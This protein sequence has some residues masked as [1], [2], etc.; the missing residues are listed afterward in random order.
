MKFRSLAL[1][2]ALAFGLSVSAED[3][4][5]Y[6]YCHM[7]GNSETT[8]Y[9]LGSKADR[10]EKYHA[11][12]GNQPVFDAEKVARIEGG[13]RDAFIMRGKNNDYLMCVT[14]MCNRK[15]RCWNNYGIDLLHSNDLVHWTSVTFDFR[16]G[17]GIFSDP[18]SPDVIDY[19]KVNRVWAP[20][21]IWDK[22]YKNGKG[23]WLVYYSILTD[24]PGEYDKIYYSYAN[25]DF[26]TLTKPQLF[27]DKGI[28]VIDCHIDWNEHD[29][30]Y[31]VFYKKE[32]AAGYDRGIWAATFEKLPVSEWTDR[33]HITNEGKEQVEGV[34]AFRLIGED[35]WKVAYIR[36]SG[37]K[38]YKIC[39]A[40][41]NLTNVDKGI[42]LPES[43]LP[44]H[45]SFMTVTKDEYDML[46]AW[47]KL[48]VKRSQP[49]ADK[50]KIDAILAKTYK[51]GAVKKL[52]KLYS[53]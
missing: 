26:T 15:S 37:G 40:D 31:H 1:C 12:A 16:Q 21:V 13:T 46:E 25:D 48:M 3:Y 52:L 9:A 24:K 17:P 33:F 51:K 36:Y 47:S 5:G 10:G 4:Y 41:A 11:L 34:S 29:G 43:L 50:A 53:K 30:L 44:Q 39:N 7:S 22:D 23:G 35:A 14:D 38:A 18:E 49:D 20:Q 8:L 6:L 42:T 28:S 19:K 45:G 2:C 32:G 27:Y